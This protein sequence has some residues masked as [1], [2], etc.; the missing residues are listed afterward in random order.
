MKSENST[1]NRAEVNNHAKLHDWA[2]NNSWISNECFNFAAHQSD[3]KCEMAF[4]E[5]LTGSFQVV[6]YDYIL[7][8]PIKVLHSYEPTKLLPNQVNS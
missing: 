7:L 1:F 5:E 2:T 3:T 6:F 4:E 8:Q